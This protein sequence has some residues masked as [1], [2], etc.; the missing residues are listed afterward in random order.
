MAPTHRIRQTGIGTIEVLI[1]IV[2]LSVGL[3]AAGK[4][5]IGGRVSAETSSYAIT[6]VGLAKEYAEVIKMDAI[7]PRDNT[8]PYLI[9]TKDFNLSAATSTT[10]ALVS[11]CNLKACKTSAQWS[12]DIKKEW[13]RRVASSIPGGRAVVCI[14]SQSQQSSAGKYSWSCNNQGTEIAIKVGWTDRSDKANINAENVP[15]LVI[16]LPLESL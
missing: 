3:L 6:G 1:S 13:A 8:S 2:V 7:S 14:D 12:Y 9:D 10:T 15:L 16:T 5:F 4:L 11:D